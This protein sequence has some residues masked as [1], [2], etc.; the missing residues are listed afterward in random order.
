VTT[1][2]YD[3]SGNLQTVTDPLSHVTTYSY[4]TLGNLIQ[5]TDAN[6]NTINMG[7]DWLSRK[8]S[9]S[10]PDMGY[11]TYEYDGN[12]NLI[13][14]TDAKSQTVTLTYDCMNRLTAKLYPP[15][16]GMTNVSYSYDS[17]QGG[18]YG[19]GLRTGMT[20]AAGN[21]SYKYDARSRLIQEKRTIDAVIY[22]TGF[23]YDAGSRLS[24]VTYPTGETATQ[25]YDPRGLLDTLSGSVVGTLVSQTQYNQL[26]QITRIDLGSGA[27]DS[28]A[29]YGLDSEAPSGYWGRLWQIK[30]SNSSEDIRDVRHTWDA[31]GNLLQREDVLAGETETFTYDFLGRLTSASGVYNCSLS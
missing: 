9:M 24:S 12:G 19:K 18:N 20:D 10:D 7:Y 21:I 4:D 28:F 6:N 25:T 17:T 8:T 16:S 26:G 13:Q 2:G 29:Y 5:G 1:Y 30:T 27:F 22:T 11:W 23:A 3:A 15:G 14:Q 31:N